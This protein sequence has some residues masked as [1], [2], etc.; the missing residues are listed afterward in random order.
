MTCEE[1]FDAAYQAAVQIRK[2]EE[3]S[4]IMSEGI[5]VQGHKYERINVSGTLD[6]TAKVDDLMQWEVNAKARIAECNRELEMAWEIVAGMDSLGWDVSL[7]TKHYLMAEPWKEIVPE[8]QIE[9]AKSR[10]RASF[11]NVDQIG[12]ARVREMGRG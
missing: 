3:Q 9:S 2:I 11:R 8:S 5:G 12:I 6:W 10:C 1:I 7:A 4:Q